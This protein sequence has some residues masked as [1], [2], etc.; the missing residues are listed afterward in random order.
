MQRVAGEAVDR[1]LAVLAGGAFL[2]LVVGT[3]ASGESVAAV[4]LG[5]VFLALATVG[6][7]RVRRRDRRAWSVAYVAVQLPLAF[8][9]FVLNAG[10]GA[11]LFLVVLVSQCVL[12]LPLPAVVLVCACVPF[13]HV[14]MSWSDGF[15]EGLGTLAAVVFAAIVTGLLQR[16]QRTRR[17]LATAH[18]RLGAYAA[19]A[20][21]LA[22]EQERNRVARD[23]HDGLGHALTVVQMQVKA[24]RAVLAADAARADDV[25]AKAQDQAEAALAEV[26][27]SVRA[28]RDADARRPLAEA[29]QELADLSCEAGVAT[30]LVVAG[31]PRPLAEPT[32]DALYRVGQEGLT[33]VRRHARA[34]TAELRLEYGPDAVRLDVRDD[35]TGAA[36][37]DPSSGVGVL[38]LRERAAEVG[39]HLAL[40]SVPGQGTTLRV[41]VPA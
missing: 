11:T 36:P 28:L 33:N 18:A 6:F 16:E 8:V 1:A 30:R 2:T 29:L 19:Q 40:E 12:L 24:A 13:V 22:A 41:E 9:V 35:G 14:G 4:V 7:V 37:G 26:R 25:L 21:R 34:T 17:E 27:R 38:G 23:I 39:G 3:V 31:D 10:V 20:E 15:R 32:R 5:A